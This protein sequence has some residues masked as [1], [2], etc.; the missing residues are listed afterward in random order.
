MKNFYLLLLNL[1]LSTVYI[2]FLRFFAQLVS[3]E[4]EVYFHC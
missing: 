4:N 2:I 1:G 3:A